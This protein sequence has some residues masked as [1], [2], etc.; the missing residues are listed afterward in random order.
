MEDIA[1]IIKKKKKT[2]D[3]GLL[4]R[5]TMVWNEETILRDSMKEGNDSRDALV[6]PKR[7]MC[8]TILSTRRK[9]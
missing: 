5:P 8:F 7:I 6:K 1:I 9:S 2:H 3:I 4:V